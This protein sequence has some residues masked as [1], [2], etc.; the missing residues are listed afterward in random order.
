MI[1]ESKIRKRHQTVVPREV[2]KLKGFAQGQSL[3]W[4]IDEASG[5]IRVIPKPQDYTAFLRGLGKE[6]WAGIDVD[7]YVE[8][9]RNSGDR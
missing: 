1:A 3:L 5:E 7:A 9:E 6:V 8:G 2:R 4:I